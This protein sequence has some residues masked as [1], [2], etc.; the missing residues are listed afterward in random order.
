MLNLKYY[1]TFKV[2]KYKHVPPQKDF[3]DVRA[4]SR[5]VF[6][7]FLTHERN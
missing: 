3:D 6:T 1:Q 4:Q 2:V 7:L 5:R